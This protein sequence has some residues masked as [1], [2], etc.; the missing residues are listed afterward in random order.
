MPKTTDAL[1]PELLEALAPR[2]REIVRGKV[3]YQP[4]E[5]ADGT[6]RYAGMV[7]GSVIQSSTHDWLYDTPAAALAAAKDFQNA[8]RDRLAQLRKQK[9]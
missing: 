2:D 4:W 5:L 8:S 9:G 1:S 3:S 7:G 6:T